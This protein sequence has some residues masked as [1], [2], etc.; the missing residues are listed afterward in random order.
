MATVLMSWQCDEKF[1]E[2]VTVNTRK[3]NIPNNSGK[4]LF[5]THIYKILIIPTDHLLKT[6]K[7]NFGYFAQLDLQQHLGDVT[8]PDSEHC[9]EEDDDKNNMIL[10]FT[11]LR[12][13]RVCWLLEVDF[14]KM[15]TSAFEELQFAV[16]IYSKQG[17]GMEKCCTIVSNSFFIYAKPY[18]LEEKSIKLKTCRKKKTASKKVM[19]KE[20]LLCASPLP[21]C[22]K[23]FSEEKVPI[24]PKE[25]WKDFDMNLDNVM[26]SIGV[27]DNNLLFCQ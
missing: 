20:E 9:D 19:H 11:E 6:R 17:M 25:E 21:Q 8:K 13:E 18:A 14:T 16:T 3:G 5:K 24:L 1:I 22:D 7:Q 23:L 10:K 26:D 27:H 4:K 12:R 15:K 2:K